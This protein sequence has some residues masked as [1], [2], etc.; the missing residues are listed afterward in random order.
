[1]FSKQKGLAL[2]PFLILQGVV[3]ASLLTPAFLRSRAI[4]QDRALPQMR[5]RPLRLTPLYDN[6]VVVADEQLMRVLMRLRPQFRGEETRI[7]EVEHSLRTW[8]ADADFGDPEFM[9]GQ[10]MIRLLMDHARFVELYGPETL[11]LL[12][13]EDRGVGVR[14]QEGP[15]SSTHVDHTISVLAE[16]GTPPDFPLITPTRQTTFRAMLEQSMASFSLNQ[17]E[18]EWSVATYAALL[19]PTTRWRTSEGEEVDFNRMAGRL[20]RESLPRGVCMGN[21]RLYTLVVLLRIDQQVSILTDETK[22]EILVFLKA[23]TAMLVQNQHPDGF[24]NDLWPISPPLTREP[25][26]RP[27]DR[28]GERILATGHALEWWAMAPRDVHPPRPV[29]AAAGQWL[30]KTTDELSDEEIVENYVYLTHV[31]KALAIWR[32]KTPMQA[33]REA[34]L[35]P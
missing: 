28:I 8:G 34:E 25:T 20:M 6:P 11:P 10:E 15:R 35:A 29:L 2:A 21:H 30:V 31:A 1:V 26:D 7:N 33:L 22:E 23:A 27:G 18:Y 5:E 19:P 4:H 3:I 13:D 24:W 12:M 14:V 17:L 32:N 16:V 9:T